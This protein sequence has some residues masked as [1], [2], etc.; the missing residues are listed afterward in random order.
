MNVAYTKMLI[1]HSNE[2]IKAGKFVEAGWDG[3]RIEVP[4]D[5]PDHLL[6]WL[7]RAYFQGAQHVAAMLLPVITSDTEPTEDDLTRLVLI[8]REVE[9]FSVEQDRD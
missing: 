1:E 2:M 9:D 8:Q 4:Q 3:I 5:F 6:T 7:R